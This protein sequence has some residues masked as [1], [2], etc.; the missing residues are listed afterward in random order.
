[1]TISNLFKT[2]NDERL[3]GTFLQHT[4]SVDYLRM[5]PFLY[6]LTPFGKVS[7]CIHLN[8]TL[9]GVYTMFTLKEFYNRADT[10]I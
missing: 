1:M 4:V 9:L 7:H 10:L 2:V 6:Y 3:C 8:C 5:S